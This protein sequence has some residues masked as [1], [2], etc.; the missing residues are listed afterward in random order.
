MCSRFNLDYDARRHNSDVLCCGAECSVGSLKEDCTIDLCA[1]AMGF[2]RFSGAATFVS[3]A[4][5]GLLVATLG[6]AL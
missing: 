1:G 3:A 5:A 2:A 6:K 4:V